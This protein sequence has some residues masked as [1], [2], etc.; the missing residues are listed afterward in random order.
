STSI[1]VQ[2]PTRFTQYLRYLPAL[3]PV[4]A[5]AGIAAGYV[6]HPQFP[7]TFVNWKIQCVDVVWQALTGKRTIALGTEFDRP[8]VLWFAKNAV[9]YVLFICDSL[10]FAKLAKP[11]SAETT[12]WNALRRVDPTAAAMFAAAAAAILATPLGMRMSEY[13]W[14]LTLLS[15]AANLVALKRSASEPPKMFG[16]PKFSARLKTLIVISALAFVVFLT[17]SYSEK[18]GMRPISDFASYMRQSGIPK[19]TLIANL[20]WSDYPFLLYSCPEY[21]YLSGMDPMFSY[22]VAPKRVEELEKF[23]RGKLKLSAEKLCE[24][25]G[26]RYFFLRKMYKRYAEKIKKT[27]YETLYEGLDGWLF[28]YNPS[29]TDL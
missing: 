10:I 14:P 7:N 11:R 24:L 19:E 28:E 17:E 18:K 29:P 2:T 21:R 15:L 13:A 16:G 22:A 12:R 9:P 23:R 5:A 26:A 4:A 27:G 6:A 1:S 8:G 20:A 25:T 3:I